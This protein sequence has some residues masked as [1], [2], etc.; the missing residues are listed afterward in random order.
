MLNASYDPSL[1]E[2][3]QLI[4]GEITSLRFLVSPWVTEV[5]TLVIHLNKNFSSVRLRARGKTAF[6]NKTT[7]FAAKDFILAG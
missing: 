4:R 3:Q 1:L 7:F 6:A 2:V 5:K